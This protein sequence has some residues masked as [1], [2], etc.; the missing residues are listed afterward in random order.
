MNAQDTEKMLAKWYESKKKMAEIESNI[1][2]YKQIANQIFDE[3]GEEK[4]VAGEYILERKEITKK[5]ISRADLPPEIYEE[6]HSNIQYNTLNLSKKGE[7][8]VRKSRSRKA[9]KK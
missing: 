2:R 7:K 6:Y 9:S 3:T 5:T 4:I 1:D 8:K